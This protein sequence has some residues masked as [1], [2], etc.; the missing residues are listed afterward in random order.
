MATQTI[1]QS[2]RCLECSEL[3]PPCESFAGRCLTCD[4]RVFRALVRYRIDNFISA[5]SGLFRLQAQ[6]ALCGPEAEHFR[7]RNFLA[8]NLEGHTRRFL[9]ES[10]SAW[11]PYFEIFP[12]ALDLCYAEIEQVARQIAIAA[13]GEESEIDRLAAM[14]AEAR[15]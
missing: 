1:I 4:G 3:V 11:R 15:A 14:D 6:L 10:E 12:G 5:L 9:D 13:L 8:L 7:Q 2:G